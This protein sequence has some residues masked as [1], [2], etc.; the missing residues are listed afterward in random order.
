MKN[1]RFICAQP[2]SL[3]Y[4]WQVEVMMNNFMEMGINPNNIDIVC[5]K[6]NNVIPEEWVKLTNAYPA[7]FFFYDDTR[8]SKHYISSIR[9]NILKQHFIANPELED[10]AILYHDCDIVF[11]KPI[12]W[13][14]FLEDDKWYGSDTRWYIAHSYILGKGQDVMDKMCEIV[15]IDESV[16]RDNELNSIGA[17]YLMKGINAGFWENVEKDCERL[18]NEIT[19]LNNMKKSKEP[20]YH[21]LQIW[22]ADMWAV[23]WNGWKMGKETVCHP[24]LEFAWGTSS[25]SDYDRLNILHNAGVVSSADGL[26]YKAEFMGRLPY[27]LNLNIKEGTASK[28]YYEIIQQVEKKSVLI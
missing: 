9:P 13:E 20:E 14:Q 25:E 10:E 17:Q 1:L 5:W 8:A 21:E 26:F 22:C 11:T 23:L 24:D 27:N 18:Y 2:T 15:G 7:R 16:V 28:K 6:M 19:V 4:A 12:N 3:F